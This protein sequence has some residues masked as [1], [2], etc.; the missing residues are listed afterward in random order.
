MDTYIAFLMA[1]LTLGLI[2]KAR[3]LITNHSRRSMALMFS[4]TI[5]AAL[6]YQRS[7]MYA[8]ITVLT[9]VLAVVALDTKTNGA[10]PMDRMAPT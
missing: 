2:V 5:P 10:Q 4:A 7:S 6:V 1:A 8:C 9:A 3:L